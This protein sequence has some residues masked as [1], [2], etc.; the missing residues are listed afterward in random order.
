MNIT[1]YGNPEK[2]KRVCEWTDKVFYVDYKH[3]KQRFINKEAMYEWRKSQNREIVNC[4]TCGESF[5]R[6]IRILHPRTGK[7]TQYCSN[8]CN[9]SSQEKRE[10]TKIQFL[11][12]NPMNNPLSVERIAKTKQK[13]YGDPNYNNM[14]KHKETCMTKYGVP[15]SIY[16]PKCMSNGK[17]ISNFQKRVYTEILKQ[18][19]DAKLEVY[20]HDIH[21]SIDIFIPSENKVI[22]CHGDYWHCNPN[23]CKPDYYNKL[24]HLTAQQIWDRDQQKTQILE[25]AGYQVE[26]IWENTNKNFKHFVSS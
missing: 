3:R 5:E 20:L 23:K 18:Y 21:K 26:I 6:Y 19:P 11:T 25:N 8:E 15:Y 13:R 17:R 22:E 10:K 1:C 2:I 9:R 24:V 14:E 12:K 16:L 7:P 4:L